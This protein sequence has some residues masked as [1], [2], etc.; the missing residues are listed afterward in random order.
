MS[1]DPQWYAPP[2]TASPPA[3]DAVAP[4]EMQAEPAR[5]GIRAAGRIIDTIAG[6]FIGM[7]GG[8]VGGVVTA[9]LAQSGTIGPGW[10][11]RLGEFTA[12]SL[13][14]SLIGNVLY[15]T[16]SEGLGGASIG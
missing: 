6:M 12:G 11:R 10:E 9:I 8:A 4:G 5:F 16:L 3:G 13:I 7:I 2:G 14:L 1:G 15:H